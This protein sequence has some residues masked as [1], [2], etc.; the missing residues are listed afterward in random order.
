MPQRMPLAMLPR[1]AQYPWSGLR[2]RTAPAAAY[3]ETIAAAASQAT[4]RLPEQHS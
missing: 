4:V 3:R 2:P 1:P